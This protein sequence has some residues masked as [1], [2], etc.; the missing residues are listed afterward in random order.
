MGLFFSSSINIIKDILHS[1][2]E[3]KEKET[4]FILINFFFGF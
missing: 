2:D 3:I 1:S 4:I